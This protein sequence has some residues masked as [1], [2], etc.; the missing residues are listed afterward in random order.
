MYK[1]ILVPL[2]GSETSKR[3]LEAAIAMAVAFKATLRLVHVTSDFPVMLEMAGT[4]D[5]EK[6]GDGLHQFGK[7]LLETTKAQVS[8]AGIEVTTQLRDIKSGRVA[9][10]IVDEAKAAGCDLIVIGTH[11]RRGFQHAI[12]GSDAERV[13]RE[14]TVPVLVV[15]AV[16]AAD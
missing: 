8:E 4:M 10:S 15:R 9:D 2:D 12:L 5:F 11:G 16:G 14:S 13:I 3:G 7:H 6:F 1:K